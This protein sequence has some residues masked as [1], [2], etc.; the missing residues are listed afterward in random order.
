MRS[1]DNV[2]GASEFHGAGGEMMISE[3]VRSR[4]E[5]NLTPEFYARLDQIRERGYE[6]MASAQTAGVYNL[7]APILGPDGRSIAYVAPFQGE[8]SDPR[9]PIWFQTVPDAEC[10]SALEALQVEMLGNRRPEVVGPRVGLTK[11][12]ERRRQSRQCSN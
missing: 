2:R 7:S 4:D 5:I 6:M 3:H 1:E 8:Y 12:H 11:N 9:Y 10:Q